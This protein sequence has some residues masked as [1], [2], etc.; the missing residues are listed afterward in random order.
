MENFVLGGGYGADDGIFQYK[1]C[2]AP[3]GQRDF[4]IGK[5]IFDTEAYDSLCRLSGKETHSNDLPGIGFFPEY[6]AER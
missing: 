4:Y 5:N 3:N 2:L 1:L 6:R